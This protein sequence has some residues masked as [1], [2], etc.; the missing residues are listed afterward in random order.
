[1]TIQNL[2]R[3]GELDAAT[4]RRLAY[5]AIAVF[6]I[7][8]AALIY[9]SGGGSL[10]KQPDTTSSILIDA[11]TAI[12]SYLAQRSAYQSWRER[13]AAEKTSKWVSVLLPVIV[14]ELLI[15]ALAAGCYAVLVL[16]LGGKG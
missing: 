16:I 11:G 13:H 6:S 1:M 2:Q 12:A 3:L 8:L 5:A 4:A 14:Y 9:A 7:G 10:A 15:V